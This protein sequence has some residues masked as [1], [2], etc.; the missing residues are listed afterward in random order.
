MSFTSLATKWKALL[1]WVAAD[2][3][4]PRAIAIASTSI[5]KEAQDYHRGTRLMR[6]FSEAPPSKTASATK[7]L[8]A[9]PG[10]PLAPV[11]TRI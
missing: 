2:I 5:I 6:I 10:L 8:P 1:G 4:S 3:T 9:S 11:Q 7:G